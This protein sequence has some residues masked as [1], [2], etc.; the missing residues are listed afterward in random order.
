ML[1]QLVDYIK[2]RKN[3]KGANCSRNRRI[4]V[5]FLFFLLFGFAAGDLFG[6]VISFD[7]RVTWE[8]NVGVSG[9]IPNR[10]ALCATLS[11]TGG[12]DTS[13]IQNALNKCPENQ[14]V[15]LNAGTFHISGVIDWQGVADGVVLRGSGPTNT[16]LNFSSGY[17]YMRKIGSEGALSID[18]DLSEDAVKGETH[19]RTATK[20]AWLLANHYYIIDQLDDPSFVAGGGTDGGASYREIMGNG[21]RGLGQ[22]IKV[23]SIEG[24]GPYTINFEIPLYYGFKVSQMAQIAEA[25]YDPTL[26]T[27]RYQCGIEDLKLEA[28]YTNTGAHMIKMENCSNCWIR[29]VESFNSPGASHIWTAF[30][31]RLE[32]RDSYFHDSHGYGGGQGYGVSLF[33]VTSASLVENNIFKRLHVAMM[34]AYGSSGNVFG[35]NYAFEGLADSNQDPS[36]STHGVHAYMNLWEGNYVAN[37]ALGDWTHGSSSHNTLFRNR[38]LGY[39]SGKT[40]DQTVISIERYNRHWNVVGNVLGTSGWHTSYDA[41]PSGCAASS[42]PDSGKFIYKLG[43]LVNWGCGGTPTDDLATVDIIRHGNFDYVNNA[44]VWDSQIADRNIP[45]SYYL[46][47]KPAFFSYLPWPSIGPDLNPM[48]GAIPAKNRYE[49]VSTGIQPPKNLKTVQ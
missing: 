19:V 37:K 2:E 42:C 7:R 20:P 23:T 46:P 18:L 12:D 39:E 29:R 48:V 36:I 41:C 17:I 15:K 26:H 16:I 31:Y 9:G 45:N 3:F 5:S 4:I 10:T 24:T 34:A 11:P 13:A 35:Y 38:M 25:F 14:V 8:G 40:L 32:I 44:I 22:L 1:M 47:S 33:H 43:F 30:C 6:E 27:M 49:R 21:A 28:T